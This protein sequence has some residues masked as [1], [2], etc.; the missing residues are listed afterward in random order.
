MTLDEELIEL[1]KKAAKISEY[2]GFD[3]DI[4]VADYRVGGDPKK[5]YYNVRIGKITY[6][7]QSRRV[8]SFISGVAAGATKGEMVIK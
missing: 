7:Y 2:G 3:I 6:L 1:R 8:W 4:T 5:G